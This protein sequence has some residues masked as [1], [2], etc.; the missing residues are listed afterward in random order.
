MTL[1]FKEK[2]N[3]HDEEE[4]AFGCNPRVIRRFSHGFY[5]AKT[6]NVKSPKTC[7]QSQ[8]FVK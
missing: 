5:S 3:K 1:W 7:F 4:E 8:K 6:E 2:R